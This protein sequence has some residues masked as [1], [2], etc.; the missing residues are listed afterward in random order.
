MSVSGVAT[1]SAWMTPEEL[2]DLARR[3]L[4]AAADIEELPSLLLT[5]GAEGALTR[6]LG[7]KGGAA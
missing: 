5:S 4:D 6:V 7:A 2:R 3:L 1:V